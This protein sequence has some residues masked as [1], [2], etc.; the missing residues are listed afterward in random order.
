MIQ[1]TVYY[2]LSSEGKQ[3]CNVGFF[4][5]SVPIDGE[6]TGPYVILYLN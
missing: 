4:S 3:C 5:F 1:M 6:T 2:I